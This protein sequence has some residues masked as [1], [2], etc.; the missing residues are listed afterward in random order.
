MAYQGIQIHQIRAARSLLDWTQDDLAARTGLSK[1][2]IANLEGAKTSPQ[3]VTIDKI[4]KSLELAGIEFIDDGVRL[5]KDSVV[6][7]E[8]EDWFLSLLDDV[9]HSLLQHEHRELLIEFADESKSP[10][11]VIEKINVMRNDAIKMRVLIC[12]GDTKIIGPLEE[13]RYIPTA[14]FENY[15]SLIYGDKIAVCTEGNARAVVIKDPLLAKTRRNM[16][17]IT[18]GLLKQP[19]KSTSQTR[20]L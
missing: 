11:E 5:K 7:V 20:Y 17:N 2:S 16:F 6:I 19:K 4:I 15:V 18:W 9:H 3:K 1:F 14:Y 10:L 8:G 13:Y 12:E